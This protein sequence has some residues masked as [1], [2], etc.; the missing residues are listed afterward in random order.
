MDSYCGENMMEMVSLIFTVVAF[1][2]VIVID[3]AQKRA[4]YR[5][6]NG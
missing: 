6:K 3:T 2:V 5:Q 4:E 1:F